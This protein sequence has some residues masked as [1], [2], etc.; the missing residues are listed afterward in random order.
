VTKA[1]E[2][3]YVVLVDT[4][5]NP[6]KVTSG[7][8]GTSMTDDAA[9]TPGSSSVTPAGFL[10][11]D[12]ATDPLDEGDIGAARLNPTTRILYVQ[13]KDNA[14][15]DVSVGGGTQYTEDAAAAANPVG[16]A[17]ILVREDARGGSLTTTDGDNVAAR[18]TNAGELYVKH[19]DS[20]AVTGTFWQ[21]TQPVSAA[22]LPLPTGAATAAAQLPDGHNVTIDNASGASAVNI[23]DGGN[24]ITVDGTVAVTNGTLSVVGNGAAATA[25]RVTLANDSTGV[26]ATV[27]AVTAITNALPAGTNAI[28]KLAANS[29]VDIGDVDVTSIAA[30]SNLIGNVGIGVRTS[31]GATA[32]NSTSSDG[33]TALTNSAQQIKDTAGQLYG[34][35]IYN[36]NSTAAFVQFYNTDDASVTVGTTEPLIMFTIPPGAAANQSVPMGITFGTGLSWAATSTAGGNGALTT[37]IDAVC[38][39]N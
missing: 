2:F 10:A 37:A 34:W 33:S 15:S 32:K 21:A 11:D 27:G 22:S 4:E 20:V 18:G 13:L 39:Y 17:M 3:E 5:G 36:P 16:N 23:Q 9:F 38:W 25:Q 6:Y 26:I 31:G 1:S 19:V 35:Y 7:A 14:G 28:G 12:A 8:G 30:G 24:T 29:G